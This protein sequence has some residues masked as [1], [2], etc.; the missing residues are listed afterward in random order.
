MS[1]VAPNDLAAHPFTSGLT[2][3]QLGRLALVAIS[4]EAPAGHRFFEEGGPATSMW[5]ISTGRVALDLRVPGREPLILETL[6]P[7]DELGLSWLS[8]PRQWQFGAQAQLS[9]SALE[10]D[11]AAVLSL[12]E[13]DHELGYQI[14][15]RLLSTAISRLQAARIRMLDLYGPPAARTGSAS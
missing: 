10:L 3:E 11:C 14:S 2:S 1:G 4:V 13:S 7:G 5:L 12:C 8:P 15:R 6:G 9:V